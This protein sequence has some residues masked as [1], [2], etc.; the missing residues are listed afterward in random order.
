MAR[1]CPK[2]YASVE[3]TDAV[4]GNCGSVLSVEALEANVSMDEN[5]EPVIESVLEDQVILEDDQSGDIQTET[6]VEKVEETDFSSEYDNHAMKSKTE[7]SKEEL[8]KVMSLGDWM[9]TLLLLCIPIVNVIMLIIWSV[10]EKT[11]KS[12]KHFAWA[13]LIF[14]GIGIVFSII[15]SSIIAASIVSMLGSGYYY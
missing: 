1:Y 5:N 8:E 10:D 15:F 14:M 6:F 3:K 11:N 9:L 13:Q 4:C 12:K 7:N 2:C